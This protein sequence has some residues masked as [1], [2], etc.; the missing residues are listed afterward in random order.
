[1]F[2]H[3]RRCTCLNSSKQLVR[4][5]EAARISSRWQETATRKGR[6]VQALSF[7]QLCSRGFGFGSSGISG[8]DCRQVLADVSIGIFFISL[9]TLKM[10]VT[11]FVSGFGG[12]DDACWH[13]VPKFAGL[14]PAEAVGFFRAKN[15]PARLPL[16]GK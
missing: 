10:E 3:Q 14:N 13:L 12:L 4:A 15:S 9:K 6:P 16:E 2:A 1:V 5:N 11:C 8:C 7:S